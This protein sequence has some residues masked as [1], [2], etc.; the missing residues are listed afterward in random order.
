MAD[1]SDIERLA[2]TVAELRGFEGV[3]CVDDC[4]K[5]K[6]ILEGLEAAGWVRLTEN[7]RRMILTALDDVWRIQPDDEPNP[8]AATLLFR[9]LSSTERGGD[10]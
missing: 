5:A 4:D 8:H 1:R 10:E 7:D 6:E 9:R 2:W 3:M